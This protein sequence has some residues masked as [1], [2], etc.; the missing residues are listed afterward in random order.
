MIIGLTGGTGFIGQYLL[1]EYCKEHEFRVIHKS[2]L[3][4]GCVSADSITYIA[5]DYSQDDMME[6]FKGCEG[7]INLGG[8]LSNKEREQSILNYESNITTAESLFEAA[9]GLGITNV[10]NASS[11]LVYNPEMPAPHKEEEAAAPINKYGMVKL[12]IENLAAF[13]NRNEGMAIK[14][15]RFAEVFGT[16]TRGGYMMDVFRKKC[17]AGESLEVFDKQGKELLYVKDAAKAAMTACLK[18]DVKGVFNIGSGV[19]NTNMEIA[20]AFCKVYDNTAEIIDKSK[21]DEITKVNYMD[22]TK[23]S[24]VLGFK[25]GFSLEDAIA[26]MRKGI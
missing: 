24:E 18:N 21:A 12:L 20:K 14:T 16:G 3:P 19:F 13:Y 4:E 17:E 10:V 26:D 9:K 2:A 6:N 23:A 7:I 11:R 15:L 5:S 8:L 22:I 1:R 25:T